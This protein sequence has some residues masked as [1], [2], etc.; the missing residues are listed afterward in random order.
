MPSSVK[1]ST[2]ALQPPTR[3]ASSSIRLRLWEWML[4]LS[5]FRPDRI[6]LRSSPLKFVRISRTSCS[7][8]TAFRF[9]LFAQC[10]LSVTFWVG[11]GSDILSLVMLFPTSLTNFDS[12]PTKH[13][14]S[15]RSAPLFTLRTFNQRSPRWCRVSQNGGGC[16]GSF[17]LTSLSNL[18]ISQ[19][20]LVLSEFRYFFASFS[21]QNQNPI[22]HFD[23][24][25]NLHT[26]PSL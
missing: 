19:Y 18:T 16:V 7:L 17:H 10:S 24:S 20:S 21:R 15:I 11:I 6:I 2:N 1:T 25:P 22:K 14:V 4:I 26:E 12:F 23:S 13:Y 5:P 9:L 8:N 3:L